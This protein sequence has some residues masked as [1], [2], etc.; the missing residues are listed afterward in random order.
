MN[1]ITKLHVLF[2][3]VFIFYAVSCTAK[4]EKQTY[5]NVYDLHFAMRFDSAVVYPWRE[6]G[7]Y[8]NYTIPAYIQDSNRN[9]FA[10]KYFKGFPF[11]KRLR[12]EYEQRI[13]LP[14]NNIKE[15]VIGFEGKGDNI[16]LVSI[17]LD[18]IGKQENI[19]FSDTL[20]FR[21]DSILS[22]FTQNIN[23]NNAEMLN[24]RINVEGEIDK[25][26][27]IA[28]SRLDILIDGK[29]IDEFPVRTLSPL[30]VDKKI[31]YTGINV[32]RKIG[33]EQINEINDKK[34]IGL[35]ESVHG[36]DGIKNLA[37]QLIIQAVER[38]NCKLV[39]QE[40]PLE[41]SFAY[42]RF[43]QDDNYEL[44]SSLVINHATINFLNR[45]RSFNSGK[46]KDS[47]V[48]L[49]GMDYNSI[50]SSTQSSA[51]DIF[52]FITVLNQKSQI[53][54]V[55]QLSLLLMKK[56]RNCAINF[57]DTHRDKIKKLLTAEEIE[58]ILHILRVSKQAGDA[59]IERFIRRDSIMF[60][61]ARFLIDK[62]A[63]DENVKTV[64]Y[65][66]AG[67][68][69]PI[70]SYPAVPCIPFGR[71]MRKAYGE[72]YSPLLFLIGSG[73]AMAYDEHYNRKDNWLS[74][75]P[76]NSMEY[77]LSLIDDN[78][79]YTPLTVDFNEL[80]LSRL[81]GSHHIP[82][83]FYPFN[84]YQRFKGV[85]FIKSTDCTHKDEKEISFE[86]AYDRLI[87][88]IKQ[89]QEKIKEIQKRIENL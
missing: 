21:P 4:L 36:N 83:E 5:T 71:Y 86:K 64:I 19:L 79:F 60:V 73:E 66:H 76:E 41:Q 23:L 56:D 68:I 37:Y 14:N 62:F 43:I 81:Q 30:I 88:K 28:F 82:Q 50:L 10:K 89:R 38:L 35:G 24:V 25:D 61:N 67:H 78:V 17:I 80:T 1:S 47:K 15:A 75:P 51:M 44:D 49:Y 45:L 12:S 48:K 69:N 53:P 55:D 32:D 65:G 63:K 27:Y 6:N 31:N 40:M 29:P 34:I 74:R 54:E 77:F 85:F 9:L 33:L 70:S 59:G 39:L 7:A 8:S 57:L 46:T 11:S 58:C 84:L 42:N 16:K 22:L 87:M 72:S 13:L 52:D 18:A 20:R 2:F 26:A 3:F